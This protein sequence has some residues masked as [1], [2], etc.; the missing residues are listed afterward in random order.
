MSEV[1]SNLSDDMAAAVATV[2]PSVVRIA[3]RDRL[4]GSGVVWSTDGIIVTAHHVLERDDNINVGLP[5]GRTV[6]ATLVGRDPTTDL[7]IIRV[8]SSEL[9]PAA[10]GNSSELQ[11]GEDVIA[12]G[13]A[14]GLPGGPT[15]SKGVV[16]ALGRTIDTDATT[17]I[18]DLIQT[19]GGEEL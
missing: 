11:V 16:S 15:V 8:D 19:T 4:P 5:D 1:L 2:S 18:V 3:A 6:S 7:A 9:Q 14:L 12:I 10:L 13:H 17:T